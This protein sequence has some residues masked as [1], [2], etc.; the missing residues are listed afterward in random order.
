MTM[1]M[2]IQA[3]IPNG[4]VD[5]WLLDRTIYNLRGVWFI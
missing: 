4:L 3:H 2:K 1:E 5:P